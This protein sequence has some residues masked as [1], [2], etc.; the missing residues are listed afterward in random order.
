MTLTDLAF[1][2]ISIV[3]I[4][5]VIFLIRGKRDAISNALYPYPL[6]SKPG[7]KMFPEKDDTAV[8][9][10]YILMCI[11]LIPF[12]IFIGSLILGKELPFMV[13]MVGLTIFYV[14]YFVQGIKNKLSENEE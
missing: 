2:L 11:G 14:G 7:D 12:F 13:P 5:L 1:G 3:T 6:S 8:W 10:A 9:I 4:A